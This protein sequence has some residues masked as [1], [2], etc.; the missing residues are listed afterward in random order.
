M[1]RT[2]GFLAGQT[3]L[4]FGVA[5]KSSLA[6]AIAKALSSAGM[7]LALT[8]QSE[9][10]ERNIRRLTE[11]MADVLVIPCDVTDDDQIAAVFSRVEGA[12]DRLDTLVHSIAFANREDLA[13]HFVETSRDG[14]LLS[15]NI[16]AFSLTALSRAA[17][18]LFEKSGGGSIMTLT[19]LGGERVVRNYNLMGVSKASLE[20]SVRYL[21]AD[22]GEKN[23][24]VNAIS[25]G[26]VKTLSAR[27]V[28][29]FTSILDQ[30]KETAPLR[31]NVEPSEVANT[32][33]F[34]ASPLSSGIT[35]EV[36]HVDCG[37]H[38]VAL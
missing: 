24:R 33:L 4:I 25:A 15:Q 18:P 23:V 28:G 22:L 37:Y 32:A 1:S 10:Q 16:S 29:G 17:L 9:R 36:I 20:M 13:G 12:F 21:A 11:D 7:R 2:E 14:F 38:I 31:R 3:G 6:W 19:Y 8:Y 27:G 5:H 34:L 30:M 26:P 35:G